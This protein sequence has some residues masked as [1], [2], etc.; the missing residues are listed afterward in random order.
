[1]EIKISIYTCSG[2]PFHDRTIITNNV[3]I[4]CGA[5]F[6]LIDQ[7]NL[8]KKSTTINVIYPF[9]N[10]NIEWTSAAYANLIEDVMKQCKKYNNVKPDKSESYF[11]SLGDCENRLINPFLDDIENQASADVQSMW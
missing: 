6:D 7:K 9:L 8:A 2:N 3:W 5:G 4:G 10:K 1:M 11:F